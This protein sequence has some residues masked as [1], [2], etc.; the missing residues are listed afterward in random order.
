MHAAFRHVDG[1][2]GS[3]VTGINRNEE[4]RED[5]KSQ[6]DFHEGK[7]RVCSIKRLQ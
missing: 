4:N 6:K 2:K 1:F 7:S 5:N 3:G